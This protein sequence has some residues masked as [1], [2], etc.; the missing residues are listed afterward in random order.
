[1]V[2]DGTDAEQEQNVRQ[3]GAVLPDQLRVPE[4]ET[5]LAR[6][7]AEPGPFGAELLLGQ[8]HAQLPCAARRHLGGIDAV[9][10]A[11]GGERLRIPQGIAAAPGRHVAAG[12]SVKGI[13]EFLGGALEGGSQT[14][15]L[16]A[17]RFDGA[18]RTG[19]GQGLAH[20]ARSA[21]AGRRVAAGR[22]RAI[23]AAGQL[24]KPFAEHRG[25]HRRQFA[26]GRPQAM[27]MQAQRNAIR[28]DQVDVPTQLL[29]LAVA[30]QPGGP[31]GLQIPLK[32]LLPRHIANPFPQSL[33]QSAILEG[34]ETFG[35]TEQLR[36]GWVF[37]RQAGS[38][39]RGDL[40]ADRDCRAAALGDQRLADIVHDI[41][42][43]VGNGAERDIGPV[44]LQLAER[45]ARQEFMGSVRPVVDDRVGPPDLAEP[46]VHGQ[47][48]MR[49]GHL[50][51]VLKRGV[52]PGSPHRLR[53]DDDVAVVEFGD[54]EARPGVRWNRHQVAWRRPECLR[55]F[56]AQGFRQ[57]V[58]PTGVV[59][60]RQEQHSLAR[61]QLAQIALA[62]EAHVPPLLEHFRQQRVFAGRRVLHLVAARAQGGE[63]THQA[64]GHV[65]AGCRDASLAEAGHVDDGDLLGV[66]GR[67]AQT[68][69]APG[70]F[71]QAVDALS[72]E[73]FAPPPVPL[74]L[75]PLDQRRLDRAI[76][77]GH[78]RAH[79]QAGI[80]DASAGLLVRAEGLPGEQQRQ[81]SEYRHVEAL[82]KH[83]DAGLSQPPPPMLARN[84]DVG[85][86]IQRER[87][88]L[89]RA[90]N[91]RGIE[92]TRFKR[93]HDRIRREVH[94]QAPAVREVDEDLG[95]V[96]TEASRR[97]IPAFVAVRRSEE[98]GRVRMVVAIV[99][100]R[101]RRQLLEVAPQ[102]AGRGG[103]EQARHVGDASVAPV[104]IDPAVFAI[105]VGVAHA[106]ALGIVRGQDNDARASAG[107]FLQ[108]FPDRSTQGIGAPTAHEND[109]VAPEIRAAEFGIVE[110]F[111]RPVVVAH[112]APLRAFGEQEAIH[113]R[114][115]EKQDAGPE[116]PIKARYGERSQSQDRHAHGGLPLETREWH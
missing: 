91:R 62:A 86:V 36:R 99:R 7:P 74:G 5:D 17:E 21:F 41:D 83:F 50:V 72:P 53:Q 65:Q 57:C 70:A 55:D 111:R 61:S 103:L 107:R 75:E 51:V 52:H 69:P 23:P 2:P 13:A 93:P 90:E 58:E 24:E 112:T 108:S 87:S 49:R 34:A 109:L 54:H 102:I 105:E 39:E 29:D 42:I 115:A 100:R 64:T 63:E 116:R 106:Q 37:P 67:P 44:V 94:A 89:G 78:H 81:A 18:S 82:V 76:E 113:A 14:F 96:R 15:E 114:K 85:P 92:A 46:P 22:R 28:V 95:G 33:L 38:L 9:E 31:I 97:L 47:V 30:G 104:I 84:Q 25:H 40:M 10:I 35:R 77:F 88:G 56:G 26:R 12:E 8:L 101:L 59:S 73:G 20:E 27:D 3:V 66:V 19:S 71:D 11:S 43:D 110:P 1:M 98:F 16:F 45:T 79:D 60:D 4:G 80:P 48:L 32:A 68:D 6:P